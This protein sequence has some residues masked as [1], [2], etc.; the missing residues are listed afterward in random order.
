[1]FETMS[2][3]QR[4]INV[5]FIS[6]VITWFD[7]NFLNQNRA[8]I[9][10][11]VINRINEKKTLTENDL[12]INKNKYVDSLRKQKLIHDELLLKTFDIKKQFTQSIDIICKNANVN[13]NE[14]ISS[15]DTKNKIKNVF[16][17][18]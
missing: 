6:T 5:L 2:F 12:F 9:F 4:G 7:F 16:G 11:L 18:K 15:F 10:D 8:L 13:T 14:W 3:I 17:F 1:M